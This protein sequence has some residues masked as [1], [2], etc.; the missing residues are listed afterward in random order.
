MHVIIAG[1]GRVGSQLALGLADEGHDVV[2]IDKNPQ[3]FRRLGDGFGGRALTG[4]VFDRDTLEEAGIKRAQAFIAV[5]SGDNSN[6]VSA[7]TAKERYGVDRVVARIYDPERAAIYERTGVTTIASARWTAEAVLRFLRP[8]GDR[9]EGS[10]GPGGGDVVLLTVTVPQEV[11][12]VR[13]TELTQ[14][15]RSVLVAV[16]REGVTRLPAANALLEAGDQLHLAVPRGEVD[17][18]REL[19][20]GLAQE[21]H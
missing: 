8:E 4:I 2:I 13:V 9:V 6:V 20:D 10:V 21:V 17:R 19:V 15:G 7:R 5:T 1:C 3:A 14:E 11:H 18:A 12:G 16:T